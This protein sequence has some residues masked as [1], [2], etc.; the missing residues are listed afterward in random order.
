MIFQFFFSLK[1]NKDKYYNP[2]SFIK[3][4]ENEIIDINHQQDVHEFMLN[5]IDKLENRLKN[6]KNENLMKYFFQL[7]LNEERI[8]KYD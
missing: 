1:S 3:N 2:I 4:Y 7:T 6:T 8:F 5:L